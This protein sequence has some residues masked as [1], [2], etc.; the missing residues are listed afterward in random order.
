M[1]DLDPWDARERNLRS[2][3]STP[4][5]ADGNTLDDL[6]AI[7]PLVDPASWHGVETPG[8]EWAWHEYI[9]TRQ[10]TYLTGPGSAGKSL[11]AQQ[12]CTCVAMG[13]PFLG[14]E[15]RL[16]NAIYLTCEDDQDELHRRQ[17]AICQSLGIDLRALSGKLHLVSLS[18]AINSELLS[19]GEDGKPEPTKLY[20]TLD[21]V[22]RLTGA[23]F[24]ALDNVAHLFGGN[25]NIR[26]E[27]ANFVA[28]L[29]RL[30]MR[31]NASVLFIGHPNK[32]GQDFSGSTAWENQVRSRLYMAAPADADG[33]VL[34]PD[35][36]HLTRGKANYA[37]NGEKLE[38]HWHQWAFT[39]LD[40]LPSNVAGEIR[41]IARANGENDA[42]LRCLDVRN[43]QERPVSESPASR[44]YAPKVFASMA[45]ARGLK[46]KQLENAMERLFRIGAIERGFVYRDGGEGKDRV[47]VRRASADP[48]ADHPLTA[49]AD[50]PLTA[51]RLPPA[52]TP[53]DKSI[54]GAATV[55]AAPFPNDDDSDLDEPVFKSSGAA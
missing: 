54:P 15:T 19:I 21:S 40:D 34:D 39:L 23:G 38:F 14:V 44:T 13:L 16:G 53:I 7:L 25:E 4:I 17:K 43:G 45:E 31:T 42:F 9:P 51:R 3:P 5:D 55:A 35:M 2:A 26:H 52:H 11:L 46:Q 24:V 10:A 41:D 22:L 27:V 1:A 20:R 29:N 28:L 33:S 37:R 18:G 50:V 47:G 48:S 12:L 49:P 30:A 6:K 32:A 8:R 36:R